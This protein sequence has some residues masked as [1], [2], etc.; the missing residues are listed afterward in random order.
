M[1]MQVKR[2]QTVH[3]TPRDNE[4]LLKTLSREGKRF[5]NEVRLQQDG[6]FRLIWN[7]EGFEK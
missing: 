4:W 3:A 1:P 5:G 6:S 7:I 2:F